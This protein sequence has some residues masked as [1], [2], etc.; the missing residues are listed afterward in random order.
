MKPGR[1]QTEKGLLARVFYNRQ[2][3]LLLLPGLI[4]YTIFMYFPMYGLTLAF[5]T[6]KANLGILGSPWIGLQNYMYV[7]RTPDFH[8]ALLNT[9]VISVSRL[10]FQFP[11]PVILALLIN[12]ISGGRYKKTIQTIFTFPHFLSWVVV[13][14]VLLNLLGN[15]GFVNNV[16]DYLGLGRIG[17][18]ST[19]RLFRPMLYITENWKSAGWSAIIYMAAISGIDA[20][21]Y[22]SAE[23]DGVTRM[24][25]ILYITIPG[26]KN[27]II[28]LFIL[29]VGNIMNAGFDQIFN[30]QNAVVRD[31]ADILDTYVYRITF[32]APPDFG[33][34]TAISLFKSVLNFILLLSADRIAKLFGEEGLFA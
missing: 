24:K 16:F 3:Y 19:P 1:T 14:S 17:F 4:W 27:T 21:Q 31:T 6:Y 13:A 29:A 20:E 8:K 15:G 5:K 28:V 22:E 34:S 33:F 7:V 23:I 2:T 26:I 18:L 25:K 11:V 10:V 9:F 30:M 32:K 12:E